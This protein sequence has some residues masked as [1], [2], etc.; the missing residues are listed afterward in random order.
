MLFLDFVN[1]AMRSVTSHKLRSILTALGLIIGIASVV[2][3]TSIGRG[4][5]QYILAEF[6]QFGSNLLAVFPG[7]TTT[8][9]LSGATISTVRPLTQADAA[10]L[11]KLE[12]IIAVVPLV[13]GNARIEATSKQRRASVF[14]VG[15]AVPEVWKIKVQLGR[16]LPAG[17]I[18]NP[19]AFAVLGSKLRDELFGAANPLGQ[20]IRIGTDRYRV[21]GVM[22]KKGQMLGFDMD[23]SIYIPA[24]KA[25]EMFDRE[26]LMEIDVLYQSGISVQQIEKNIRRLLINRHGEED[27]TLITQNQM[28]ESMDDILNILTLAIAAL[29]GISLLVGSVGILTIMT[30]AV[31]ERIGEIGLLRALGAEQSA[32]FQLFLLEALVLSLVGGSGGIALGIASSLLIKWAV[33]QLPVELAWLY[34]GS[35]FALSLVIGIVAGVL[36]ALRAARLEPLEALRTE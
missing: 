18:S 13:Q 10:S 33:P 11:E 12:H 30:I 4:V 6:T 15:A 1:L 7:K 35:A 24:G 23:D 17:E 28:L 34:I 25:L 2:I 26:S 20:R 29:G 14:G 22:E 5:H 16:F 3:L 21:I 27:F 9:G 8:M 36:P 19:R 32:V 31:S